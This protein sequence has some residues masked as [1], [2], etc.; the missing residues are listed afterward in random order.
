MKTVT[1]CFSALFGNFGVDKRRICRSLLSYDLLTANYSSRVDLE[2]GQNDVSS[3]NPPFTA[4][5]KQ[6][7]HFNQLHLL[8]A[9]W[10]GLTQVHLYC[11]TVLGVWPSK[12]SIGYNVSASVSFVR[13]LPR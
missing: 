4:V 8:V 2:L 12:Q 11:H 10:P 5:L 6:G 13:G 7:W 9:L 3:A 1:S